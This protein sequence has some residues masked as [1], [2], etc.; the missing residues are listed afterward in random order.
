MRIPS[1]SLPHAS[2]Y[3]KFGVGGEAKQ[4]K[5]IDMP[6]LTK[7]FIDGLK[8]KSPDVF[9]WDSEIRGLGVRLMSS[10]TMTFIVQYRNKPH[11]TRRVVIG[12]YGILTVE[13]ACE[14]ARAWLVDVIKGEDP[15]AER[16]A[17]IVNEL[18]NWYLLEAES[19]SL[20]QPKMQID[21]GV[22]TGQ[23]QVTY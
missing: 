6:C 7:K 16:N 8:P 9:A 2:V 3:F 21:Q 12:Q 1:L 22:Y 14:M 18:C 15:S 5:T 4:K 19:G 17:F 20:A 11:C 10:G 13:L 23:R